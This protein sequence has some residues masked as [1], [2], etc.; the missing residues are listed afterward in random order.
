VVPNIID[1][2]SDPLSQFSSLFLILLIEVIYHILVSKGTVEL[3]SIS[4]SGTNAVATDQHQSSSR[5]V[6]DRVTEVKEKIAMRQENH[7]HHAGQ[8]YV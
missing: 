2:R 3:N 1:I 8:I 5:N 6:D 7:T 4:H